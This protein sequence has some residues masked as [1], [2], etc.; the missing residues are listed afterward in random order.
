[1][2]NF[3]NIEHN[4]SWINISVPQNSSLTLKRL[5]LFRGDQII[6]DDKC[7]YGFGIN[8]TYLRLRDM[9]I[10]NF[11]FGCVYCQRGFVLDDDKICKPNNTCMN[12]T[13]VN[14]NINGCEVSNYTSNNSNN[15]SN[16]TSNTSN[17]TNNS[18]SISINNNSC[19]FEQ[20]LF[21]NE[22]LNCSNIEGINHDCSDICGNT[23]LYN[24]TNNIE[25][26]DGNRNSGDG[27]SSNCRI[28]TNF[29][30]SRKN[31]SSPDKCFNI[32]P[33]SLKMLMT[34][35]ACLIFLIFDRE[36][37]N[38]TSNNQNLKLTQLMAVEFE[39]YMKNQ[40]SYELDLIDLKTIR[41]TF[42]F[43]ISFNPIPFKI[44]ILSPNH[45]YDSNN[46]TL[47][48]YKNDSNQEVVLTGKLPIYLKTSIEYKKKVDMVYQNTKIICYVT[49]LLSSIPFYWLSLIQLFWFLLD[50]MQMTNLIVY[51]NI[52]LPE[53]AQTIL[54]LFADTNLYF[55]SNLLNEAAGI[56]FRSKNF[57][58]KAIPLITAPEKFD[59]LMISSLFMLNVGSS[60]F[61]IIILYIL[62]GV[63]ILTLNSTKNVR[64]K[65]YQE[66]MNK[67]KCFY[68]QAFLMR[69][70]SIF[71][72]GLCLATCLQF[73]SFTT[74]NTVYFYNY[75]IAFV[76]SIYLLIFMFWIFKI[77][78]NE[79]AFFHDE[80]YLKY[81]SSLFAESNMDLFI[82]RN[83]F[84]K[85]CIKKLFFSIV[86]VFFYD[87]PYLELMC[88]VIFQTIDVILTIKYKITKVNILNCFLLFSEF[89]LM[90]AFY[91]TL[92][93][94]IYF[95]LK[96]DK[97]IIISSETVDN[98]LLMGWLLISFL[99]CFM[100][101]YFIITNWN[102]F[103]MV[104]LILKKL[105]IL[106]ERS[107]KKS[108]FKTLKDQ[109]SISIKKGDMSISSRPENET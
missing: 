42:D 44:R 46:V 15:S 81:Y 67:I 19:S 7:K 95:D 75:I 25:C 50:S 80:K 41:I 99:F 1:M 98:F 3:T 91:M 5:E 12:G 73:R 59:D 64:N 27:C 39:D 28:E 33:L 54:L 8:E 76:S 13:Q 82:G 10:Q 43:L 53:N 2:S 108:E 58:E 70:Q 85:G 16:S 86:V 48:G 47:I 62:Y 37:G 78:N 83:Y 55:L 51:L 29:F 72:W 106:K 71:F 9:T 84:L 60:I 40:Y 20:V 49:L 22:C 105:K 38:F 89:F 87:Y 74:L 32:S 34:K 92:I 24:F 101:I 100:A 69:I 18:H 77:S 21:A 93:I 109:E 35:S 102:V 90:L 97:M 107:I 4:V 31:Y 63:L 6:Q 94:K 56:S 68:T 61:I 57:D 66:I 79:L 96:I 103:I 45:F 30:C 104:K 11:S 65:L 88:L 14:P 36:I 17:S 52:Y 26:D 23:F